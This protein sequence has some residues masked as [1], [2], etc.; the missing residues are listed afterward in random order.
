[1]EFSESDAL[2]SSSTLIPGLNLSSERM[3]LVVH[4][5]QPP[6]QKPL[7]LTTAAPADLPEAKKLED[8]E[9]PSSELSE[10]R[11]LPLLDEIQRRRAEAE[12]LWQ[13][14]LNLEI[15]CDIFRS[16]NSVKS[17]AF[18]EQVAELQ[19]RVR[20]QRS[21]Q[22]RLEEFRDTQTQ[23]PEEEL[24]VERL[25]LE[26]EGRRLHEELLSKIRVNAKDEAKM[27]LAEEA[28]KKAE[29]EGWRKAAKASLEIRRN[30][31]PAPKQTLHPKS[32]Q[33]ASQVE[34]LDYWLPL[35]FAHTRAFE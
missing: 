18:K 33:N 34:L 30:L 1:M 20:L 17:D 23:R 11:K 7:P 2:A 8:L 4:Q 10:L 28:R 15:S 24:T 19:Q 6:I 9:P 16:L 27:A 5:P 31:K 3:P 32:R 29:L 26:R 25:Q 35:S 21:C 12:R 14:Q 13:E 22:K